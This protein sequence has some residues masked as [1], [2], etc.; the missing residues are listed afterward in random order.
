MEYYEKLYADIIYPAVY[1]KDYETPVQ[2]DIFDDDTLETDTD[3]IDKSNEYARTKNQFKQGNKEGIRFA[4]KNDDQQ[5]F[6]IDNSHTET[7]VNQ[8]TIDDNVW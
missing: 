2:L 8:S 4:S 5:S 6:D 7:P 3:T 1:G